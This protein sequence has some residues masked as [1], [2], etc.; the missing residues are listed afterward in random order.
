MRVIRRKDIRDYVG[1]CPHW[2]VKLEKRGQFPR[3]VKLGERATGW[4]ASD[5]DRWLESKRREA[6]AGNG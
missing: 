2:C 3:R 4:L 1:L 5:L 6:E